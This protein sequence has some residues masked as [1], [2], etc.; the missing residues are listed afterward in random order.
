L[1]KDNVFFKGSNFIQNGPTTWIE[2]NE[3]GSRK[4]YFNNS[5]HLTQNLHRICQKFT[6]HGPELYSAEFIFGN[7]S[8]THSDDIKGTHRSVFRVQMEYGNVTYNY[9]TNPFG[10]IM[11]TRALSRIITQIIP[12]TAARY[13]CLRGRR[14]RFL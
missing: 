14:N 10:Y 3:K 5:I 13:C 8:P 7:I 9:A 1:N 4:K 6:R 2:V 11:C 12:S